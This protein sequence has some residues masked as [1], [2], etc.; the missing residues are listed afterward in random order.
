MSKDRATTIAT[1]S[2][3]PK[4]QV[5]HIK[6]KR[7]KLFLEI[8]GE[9]TGFTIQA[10]KTE[11]YSIF[12]DPAVIVKTYKV[13][14]I[15]ADIDENGNAVNKVNKGH[16]NVTRDS[17]YY[18]G[19]K[20]QFNRKEIAPHLLLNREFIPA[21]YEQNHYTAQW[22][23]NFPKARIQS[24]SRKIADDG[25]NAFRLT[26]FGNA[27]LPAKPLR[28]QKLLDG[29]DIDEPR[30]N[31]NI[32][33][34]VLIHVGGTY[35]I[36]GYDWLGGSYGCFCF[37]PPENIFSTVKL[38]EKAVED[39]DYDD[40]L[41]NKPWKEI[42]QHIINLSFPKSLPIEIILRPKL[43]TTYIPQKILEE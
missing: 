4:E 32:A 42:C 22:L 8:T 24:I 6:I 16:F 17:W 18:L 31:P 1:A 33:K 19:N 5:K 7:R 41:S 27:E 39:D 23:P 9:E 11:L 15:L 20:I 37:I 40:H 38:A 26:R 30:E 43:S 3:N 29:S 10:L 34:D 25:L 28:T 13:N 35:S 2:N 21:N 14:I 36:L 12:S